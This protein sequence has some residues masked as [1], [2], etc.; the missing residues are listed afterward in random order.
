[1]S[2]YKG[3]KSGGGGYPKTRPR[4]KQRG[5][6][7]PARR[8]RAYKTKMGLQQELKFFD[9]VIA[10]S[11]VSSTGAIFPSINLIAQGVGEE[12]R[13][14]R[15][16]IIRS[17]AARFEITLPALD[18]QATFN[19]GGDIVRIIIFKDKQANGASAAVLDILETATYDSY[20]N[21]ANKDRFEILRDRWF[22]LNRL[23]SMNDSI[24]TGSFPLV[25]RWF[26]TYIKIDCPIQFS[27][28][29][30]TIDEIESNNISY[31]YISAKGKAGIAVQC[32]RLR[33]DG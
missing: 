11:I 15:K 29:G 13:I 27:G 28:T 9:V 21:L 24:S 20:R 14:G 26:A 3:S 30:G 16:I 19:S 4:R 7:Q 17:I 18:A 31:L 22:T 32:T 33:Y 25:I 10:D 6:F 5:W 12:Q 23:S 1:M 2:Y 8:P